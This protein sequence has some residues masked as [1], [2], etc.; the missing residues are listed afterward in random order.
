MRVHFTCDSNSA[1]TPA[2]RSPFSSTTCG[3]S[4]A[5]HSFEKP[6]L[7]QQLLMHTSLPAPSK[8]PSHSINFIM[9]PFD[10]STQ[11]SSSFSSWALP[12]QE[13]ASESSSSSSCA[14]SP[15]AD[16]ASSRKESKSC[17]APRGVPRE[18]QGRRVARDAAQRN[19]GCN[20]VGA[21][22]IRLGRRGD[23]AQRNA[24]GGGAA[25]NT[26]GQRHVGAAQ[27]VGLARSARARPGG[28][29]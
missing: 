1:G 10:L 22:H 5:D 27:D 24:G 2:F 3:R 12:T 16:G 17:G 23:T 4:P 28:G 13:S 14:S 29:E 26:A 25:R 7:S 11:N 6:H 21:R 19:E 20:A 15:S 8:A 9:S 18:R